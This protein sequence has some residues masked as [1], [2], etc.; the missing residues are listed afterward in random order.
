MEEFQPTWFLKTRL[1]AA[2]GVG[3]TGYVFALAVRETLRRRAESGWLVPLDFVL[4]GWPLIAVNVAFYAYL[5][6]LGFWFIRGTHGRDR[7]F[8][9]GWV[10]AIL[11]S[12]LETLRPE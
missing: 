7:A 2:V 9:V 12:P 5:C 1:R 8:I 6:W 4:H 3:A 11:L 10:V